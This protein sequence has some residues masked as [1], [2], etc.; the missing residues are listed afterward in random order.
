MPSA[1]RSPIRTPGTLGSIAASAGTTDGK[2]S[3]PRQVTVGHRYA[4]C[5][6]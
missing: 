3:A 2:T 6:R 5:D 4:Y 1:S